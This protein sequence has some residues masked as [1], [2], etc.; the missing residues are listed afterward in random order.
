MSP[1]T[2]VIVP[3]RMESSRF[4]GKPL[5]DLGGRPM[6]ERTLAAAKGWPHLV[7]TDSLEILTWCARAG[8]Q[9]VRS[10]RPF[11]TGSDRVA[12]AI[13]RLP[14][15]P[16]EIV[17]NLQVDEPGITPADISLALELLHGEYAVVSTLACPLG[18]EERDDPHTVKV[19]ADRYGV[20]VDFSRKWLG[21]YSLA[22]V[23]I[24]AY[25]AAAL[26]RYA[27]LPI[28]MDEQTESLEQLRMLEHGL[29]IG[30]GRLARR[31]VSINTP[32]DLEK[33]RASSPDEP[34]AA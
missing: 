30:V 29:P 6:I 9:C 33:W 20:A 23:G 27:G 14:E 31:L 5:A 22:H 21:R 12:D 34:S 3:A 32:Q 17:V 25:R 10:D 7:A 13:R 28:G 15:P 2:M 4:P 16:P 11:A 1:R 24:Y 19:L 26:R 18:P 8:V